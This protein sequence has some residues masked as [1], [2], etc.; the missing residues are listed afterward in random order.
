[1]AYSHHMKNKIKDRL[2]L[3]I[4]GLSFFAIGLPSYILL[5][6]RTSE[7]WSMFIMMSL[8]Y[9]IALFYLSST[10]PR[11]RKLPKRKFYSFLFFIFIITV[12][13]PAIF[14]ELRLLPMPQKIAVYGIAIVPLSAATMV[15][16][17]Y[18]IQ[19]WRF[20]K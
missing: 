9:L 11:F 18:C 14:F 1:M 8:F 10:S 16:L 3:I 15:F 13:I 2:L 17:E 12:S 6:K 19:K 20:L 5:N 4:T 7:K